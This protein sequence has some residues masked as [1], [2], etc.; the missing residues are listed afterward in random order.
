MFFC[1][2][3]AFGSKTC[4]DFTLGCGYTVHL[5]ILKK[6]ICKMFIQLE[7]NILM[8]EVGQSFFHKT[9]ANKKHK[10]SLC[11]YSKCVDRKAF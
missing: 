8:D 10:Y 4:H 2:K 9:L 7:K 5:L 3:D 11:D 6:N 1:H